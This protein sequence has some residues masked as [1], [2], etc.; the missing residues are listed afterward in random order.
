[1]RVEQLTKAC[2]GPVLV[3][4]ATRQRLRDP[5][6]VT[7]LGPQEVSGCKEGITVHRVTI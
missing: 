6:T 4:E 1:L 5:V 3:S 2:G 7:C